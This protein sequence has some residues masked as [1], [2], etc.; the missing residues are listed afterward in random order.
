MNLRIQPEAA[1]TLLETQ[2]DKT[3]KFSRELMK[4][5]EAKESLKTDISKKS[6]ENI[7][8]MFVN[9]DEFDI[10]ELIQHEDINSYYKFK[11]EE[12]KESY[13]NDEITELEFENKVENLLEQKIEYE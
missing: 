4:S 5:V 10:N 9:V 8:G 1:E 12:L 7:V 3:S 6:A 2:A 13:A 11:I